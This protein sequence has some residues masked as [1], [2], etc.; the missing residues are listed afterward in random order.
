MGTPPTLLRAYEIDECGPH[1]YPLAW[2]KPSLHPS[3]GGP[4]MFEWAPIKD[5]IRAQ[6]GYRCVRCEHPY[7]SGAHGNGEWSECDDRCE[8]GG[9]FRI[10]HEIDDHWSEYDGGGEAQ[11][12]RGG[13]P[14]LMVEARWRILTVHHLDGDKRNCRWWNLAALCQRCHLTIQGRVV[15]ARV[16]PWEHSDWF[17]LY[18]AGFYAFSYLGEELTRDETAARLD[19]LLALEQMVASA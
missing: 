5:V 13:D 3:V 16:W 17:K 14:P 11:T 6:A 4:G 1:G 19:E 2:H 15:M 7:H 10:R 9:P 18:V 12:L 8:H